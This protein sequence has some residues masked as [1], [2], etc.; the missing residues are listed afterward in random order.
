MKKAILMIFVMMLAVSC[1]GQPAVPKTWNDVYKMIDSD[2][3]AKFQ[4]QIDR[5]IYEIGADLHPASVAVL[6]YFDAFFTSEPDRAWEYIEPESPIADGI[7]SPQ[8]LGESIDLAKKDT[9]Y[10]SVII[11]GIS[12]SKLDNN[13]YRYV[14]VRFVLKVYDKIQQKYFDSVGN[15]RV[16]ETNGKWL[17]Y[18][19]IQ[20]INITK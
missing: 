8:K 18:D 5:A 17:I 16:R 9:D 6:G 10:L 7:V 11:K 12:I 20:P 13:N 2:Q 14:T 1:S 19:I 4:S 3:S 15:Y